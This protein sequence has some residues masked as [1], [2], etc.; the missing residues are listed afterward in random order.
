MTRQRDAGNGRLWDRG[1]ER[2]SDDH[3]RECNNAGVRPYADGRLKRHASVDSRP[4]VLSHQPT[5]QDAHN[6]YAHPHPHAADFISRT[7]NHAP[8]TTGTSTASGSS[9]L[10][11]RPM[12]VFDDHDRPLTPENAREAQAHAQRKRNVLTKKPS[13]K[14]T[15]AMHA[16]HAAQ[17][18]QARQNGHSHAGQIPPP[19][20]QDQVQSD[21][22]SQSRPRRSFS[23]GRMRGYRKPSLKNNFG[24]GKNSAPP[25]ASDNVHAQLGYGGLAGEGIQEAVHPRSR[26]GIGS[27]ATGETMAMG[28][29][30]GGLGSLGGGD[31]S[32]V[33]LPQT[34]TG[35][36]LG[37]SMYAPGASRRH[38][39]DGARG[40]AQQQEHHRDQRDTLA[41]TLGSPGRTYGN[42]GGSIQS[43][44]V[45]EGEVDISQAAWAIKAPAHTTHAGSTSG[46]VAD[47]QRQRQYEVEQQQQQDGQQMAPSASA[48]MPV[49]REISTPAL[50][51]PGAFYSSAQPPLTR[52]QP[53]V[54]ERALKTRPS[55]DSGTSVSE[56]HDA[57]DR[58]VYRTGSLSGQGQ[59]REL[60]IANPTP[61]PQSLLSDRYPSD[62]NANFQGAA[63]HSYNDRES[64]HNTDTRYTPRAMPAPSPA[65]LPLGTGLSIPNDNRASH[66]TYSSEPM[67][68]AAYA[69]ALGMPLGATAAAQ[70]DVPL[71]PT[72]A[73]SR[74]RAHDG[75]IDR[76]SV[77]GVQSV[78][79]SV[80]YMGGGASQS[81]LGLS[82]DRRSVQ[83]PM[84]EG[85][86]AGA[87]TGTRQQ[88]G[89]PV[90]VPVPTPP[91]TTTAHTEVLSKGKSKEAISGQGQAPGQG[92]GL[93]QASQY[94]TYV[95]DVAEGRDPRRYDA[96]RG[97]MIS[98]ATGEAGP[99]P[100]S[101][102]TKVQVG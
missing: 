98:V 78:A 38:S 87:G 95:R 53:N 100:G 84:P 97:S 18:G 37:L 13:L 59:G 66:Y 54:G 24:K 10:P 96:N 41:S 36:G 73:P 75:L 45:D 17:A 28:T 93:G 63:P 16:A 62:T 83:L 6:G 65:I 31:W 80:G 57:S 4:D 91:M 102:R 19:Q 47:H 82:P 74:G 55:F 3:P 89:M 15:Q 8:G 52:R 9:E 44:G 79:G 48:P 92:Q 60:H 34:Q 72:G 12:P 56:Y 2:G 51:M 27:D 46:W 69:P 86:G 85:A 61:P 94:A 14:D 68:S 22:A 76:G 99:G 50:P 43:P 81:V 30:M 26:H 71:S 7:G 88:P 23:F 42:G 101:R 11:P 21:D 64:A 5:V 1:S 25:L 33:D 67:T 39:H 58:P 49:Q 90:S 40:G 32:L 70:L 20:Q 35:P 77:F 29:S